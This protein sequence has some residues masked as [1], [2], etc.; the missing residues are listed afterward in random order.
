VRQIC[1]HA[2]SQRLGVD[3]ESFSLIS[4][5]GMV[6]WVNDAAALRQIVQNLQ[7]AE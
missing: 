4:K 6:N 7:S 5:Q 3:P 1:P 2:V